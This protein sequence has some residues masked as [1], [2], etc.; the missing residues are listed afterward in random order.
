MTG[1]AGGKLK[2]LPSVG[3]NV[4]KQEN[5]LRAI[6]LQTLR[7]AGAGK[8]DDATAD[9]RLR[10]QMSLR[11]DAGGLLRWGRQRNRENL[12]SLNDAQMK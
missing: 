1:R 3:G 5:L 4:L 10:P 11:N 6:A 9:R 2:G 12:L 7:I 8:G